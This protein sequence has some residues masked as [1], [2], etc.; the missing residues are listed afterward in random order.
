M[1]GRA[2]WIDSS[3]LSCLRY[4]A[5][6]SKK[7]LRARPKEAKAGAG[8]HLTAGLALSK[9]AGTVEMFGFQSPSHLI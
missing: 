7:P 8:D 4:C 5:K 3:L 2:I 1:L 9:L 6:R